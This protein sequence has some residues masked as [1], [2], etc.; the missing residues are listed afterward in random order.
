VIVIT[1]KMI[2][3]A[4]AVIGASE[5][6][7]GSTETALYE[8]LAQLPPVAKRRLAFQLLRA[9]LEDDSI[10]EKKDGAG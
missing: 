2:S 1:Q 7:A 5:G 6:V 4:D 9:A 8:A 10:D 3:T